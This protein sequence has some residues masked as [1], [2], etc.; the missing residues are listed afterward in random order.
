MF[1][2]LLSI[3][4]KTAEIVRILI[5]KKTPRFQM[6][7]VC[8]LYRCTRTAHSSIKVQLIFH[9]EKCET[10]YDF[11]AIVALS[12]STHIYICCKSLQ[13]NYAEK[14]TENFTLLQQFSQFS[15]IFTRLVSFLF[16]LTALH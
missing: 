9:T 4:F 16:V 6:G 10:V 8:A 14:F 12:L 7:N 13:T 3:F 1:F 11:N 2:K 5:L 15:N